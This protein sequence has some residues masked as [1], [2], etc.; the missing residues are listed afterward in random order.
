MAKAA[1]AKKPTAAELHRLKLATELVDIH[2]EHAKDFARE[3]ELKSELKKIATDDGENFQEVIAGKGKVKVAG[4]KDGR[5]T[6]TVPEVDAEKFLALSE[7]KRK[8]L[9]DDGIIT[10]VD[11]YSGTYYGAVSVDLF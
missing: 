6:G 7:A 4:R 10:M 3:D 11:K 2:V 9:L 8:K 5:F 1:K